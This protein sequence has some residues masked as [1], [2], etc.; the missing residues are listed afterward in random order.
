[1]PSSKDF[2]S[3]AKFDGNA[4][5]TFDVYEESLL[6]VAAGRIDDRGWSAADLL[7]GVDEGGPAGGPGMPVKADTRRACTSTTSTWYRV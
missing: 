1:M 4:G 7:L 2:E 5:L 6:N 3:V